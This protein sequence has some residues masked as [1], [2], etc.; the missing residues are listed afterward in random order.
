MTHMMSCPY[1][2]GQDTLTREG[3]WSWLRVN[4]SRTTQA[5]TDGDDGYGVSE[6][7][8]QIGGQRHVAPDW[9]VGGSLAYGT[10]WYS[11]TDGSASGTGQDVSAGAALKWQ[12]GRW[13]LAAALDGGFGWYRNIRQISFDPLVSSAHSHSV[14]AHVSA[15]LRPSYQWPMGSFYGRVYVDLDG[16]YAHM[17]AYAENGA[18]SYDLKIASGSQFT[19]IG[20]P[21]IEIGSRIHWPGW[22]AK[23]YVAFGST[24]RSNAGWVSQAGFVSDQ[25]D[26]STFDDLTR[27]PR[28]TADAIIGLDLLRRQGFEVKGYYNVDAAGGYLSQGGSLR[29]GYRF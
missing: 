1:F 19:I 14:L 4:G 13:L 12:P 29:L 5:T 21:M 23:P 24:A 22:D 6:V 2:L 16:T 20:S 3:D 25:T 26:S 15:R 27:M 8:Y 28:V 7:S 18:G 10:S 9:I 11:A 17:P